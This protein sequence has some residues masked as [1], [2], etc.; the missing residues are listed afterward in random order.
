M[1]YTV[2]FSNTLKNPITVQ[3][4]TINLDTSLNLVGRNSASYGEKIAENFLHLLENSAKSIPPSPPI[5][6]QLWYDVSEPTNKLLKI[7]DGANWVPTNA[8]H[9][10]PTFAEPVGKKVGDLWSVTD[11]GQ[12]KI[13]SGAEWLLIGPPVTTQG[14]NGIYTTEIYDNRGNASVAHSVIISYLNDDVITIV[15]KEAF[16]P[17]PLIPGFTTLIPGL[18][19]STQVFDGTTARLGGLADTALS[20]KVT[21][22]VDPISADDFLR[23]DT[24]G[25]INGFLNINANGGVRVG[26]ISQTVYLEKQG[27]HA[28]LT[29]RFNGGNVALSV[30]KDNIVNE[31]VTVDGNFKRVGINRAPSVPTATLDVNG[32]GKFADTLTL[33]T[34]TDVALVAEGGARIGGDT[35]ILGGMK[36]SSM[37]TLTGKV[38]V[39]DSTITAGGTAIEPV[40]LGVWDLGSPDKPFNRVYA[41]E[42]LTTAVAFSMVPTGAVSLYPGVAAPTGWVFCT[43][44]SVERAAYPR[45]F[46]V[47]SS[48]FGATDDQHF[49][50]PQLSDVIPTNPNIPQELTLKYI[51]KT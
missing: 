14:K 4:G 10:A 34:T 37:S 23:T 44:A 24:A 12:L 47:I 8:I 41:D 1:S 35:R 5:E 29:N 26:A 20:L 28:V 31:I 22:S 51:I 25:T 50:L 19:V 48:S 42:F 49:N 13:Y 39:G 7:Y 38:I 3:D 36:V 6:G 32:T 9:K 43:G 27:N 2:R 40:A 45:L 17:N 33:S 21:G 18:N 16:T 11:T 30:M 46:G 15:A